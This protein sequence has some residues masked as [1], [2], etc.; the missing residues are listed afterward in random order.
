LEQLGAEVQIEIVPHPAGGYALTCRHPESAGR[1]KSAARVGEALAAP[2]EGAPRREDTVP[3]TALLQSLYRQTIRLKPCWRA[4]SGRLLLALLAAYL[5]LRPADL[6]VWLGM[7]VSGNEPVGAILLVIV[8]LTGLI[9]ALISF[10]QIAVAY[11]CRT[12]TV[13]HSGVQEIEW[14]VEGVRL[15]RL[16]R[17]VPFAAVYAIDLRQTLIETLLNIGTVRLEASSAE[18]YQVLMVCDVGSPGKLQRELK[19]RARL[20]AGAPSI[21]RVFGIE[22]SVERPV[23]GA[24]L[25]HRSSSRPRT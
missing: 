10:G 25:T 15:R 2:V 22:R 13:D 4:F 8:R 12:Y 7:P 18:T 17:R 9:H 19:Q 24:S 14:V 11:L 6:F 1:R 5:A 23:S 16:V 21:P 20:L 3:V